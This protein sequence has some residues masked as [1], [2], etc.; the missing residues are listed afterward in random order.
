MKPK[1]VVLYEGP[2]VLTGDPIVA[3]ATFKSTNRK[4]GDMIQTW[5]LRADVP[6]IEASQTGKDE[7]ICGQC[8][9]RRY[10]NGACYVVIGQGPQ[11]IWKSYKRGLYPLYQPSTHADY[12]RERGLRLGAYGDPASVPYAVWAPLVGLSTMCTG[13]THQYRHPNFDQRITDFCMVS[14]HTGKESERLH[15]KGVS[16]FRV[17]RINDD[18][19]PGEEPCPYTETG[20][21]CLEC[22]KCLGAG[23]ANIA[24]DVHG[25]TAS[26][27]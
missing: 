5:M 15:A 21:T 2:S 1:G 16:T 27:F 11:N 26:R 25:S 12:F 9:L 24:I 3:I 6:P 20:V 23:S 18:F 8:P 4:T 7:A 10:H 14:T 17:K 13:Y 22:G 19:L